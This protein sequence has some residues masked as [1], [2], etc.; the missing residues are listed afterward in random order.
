[1]KTGAKAKEPLPEPRDVD[2]T[3]AVGF[4][5]RRADSLASKL[6]Y[7]LSGQTILSPRQFGVLLSLSKSGPMSQREL[8]DVIHIDPS[9]LGEILRRMGSRGLI[10]RRSTSEDRR[11]V[12]LA[13]T[14]A[15]RRTLRD[16]LP[17][18]QQVQERLLEPVPPEHHAIL[19]TSLQRIVQT[20]EG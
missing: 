8:S 1:V 16:Y 17:A 7:E 4:L 12:T 18:A 5:F 6:F 11:K 3:N 13:L 14:A 9:T 15:G 2:L 20:L 10:A 19:L